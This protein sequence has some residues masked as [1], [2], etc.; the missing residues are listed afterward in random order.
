MITNTPS[1]SGARDGLD[2]SEWEEG[3]LPTEALTKSNEEQTIGGVTVEFD[4]TPDSVKKKSIRR[5]TAEE[6]VDCLCP[7]EL[8][9][10]CF[11]IAPT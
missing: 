5:A 1:E 3:S 7:V 6:K 9:R 11:F 2:E 10:R 4:V 8:C